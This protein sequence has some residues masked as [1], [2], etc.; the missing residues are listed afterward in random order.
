[1]TLKFLYIEIMKFIT[2]TTKTHQGFLLS[3]F[4]LLSLQHQINHLFKIVTRVIRDQNVLAYVVGKMKHVSDDLVCKEDHMTK[5]ITPHASPPPPPLPQRCWRTLWSGRWNINLPEYMMEG[6]GCWDRESE[7]E[8]WDWR[9]N[10]EILN[11]DVTREGRGGGKRHNNFPLPPY[12]V[13]VKSLP[14]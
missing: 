4:F 7:E 9:V 1:M 5:W 6:S 11:R 14:R 3:P 12:T 2:I 8:E 13:A 10:S